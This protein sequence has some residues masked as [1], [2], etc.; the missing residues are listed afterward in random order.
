MDQS[1]IGIA[2]DALRADIRL[3]GRA[4]GDTIRTQ[5]GQEI[6]DVVEHVRK[7]SVEFR[8]HRNDR[9]RK[10]FEDLLN[11]LS[12]DQTVEVVRAF[13]F[14]SHLA[15]IAEDQH[16]LRLSGESA[17][18]GMNDRATI[19]GALRRAR[20]AG[21]PIAAIRDFLGRA[22]V[23]PVL[24]AH[25]TEVRRKSIL[26]REIEIARLLADRDRKE[27]TANNLAEND[28]AILRAVLTL[29]HTS[30]L[31]HERPKHT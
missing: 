5:E 20:T 11:S 31:R 18:E 7:R 25:P 27:V 26:D 3:L 6:F 1:T 30:I 22:Q 16:G 10:T 19:A 9:V 8:R 14:F 2:G 24:T 4:L 15:N 13:S 17:A 29:W 23:A 12:R 21:V 28:E